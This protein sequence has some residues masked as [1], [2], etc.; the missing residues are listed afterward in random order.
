ML[1]VSAQITCVSDVIV[2]L[3]VSVM[4]HLCQWCQCYASWSVTNHV[5]VVG[6]V[7]NHLCQWY[8]LYVGCVSHESP[9][10]VV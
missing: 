2:M 4:D 1:A 7:M 3:A 6:S 9:V 10:L 5:S 8:Q